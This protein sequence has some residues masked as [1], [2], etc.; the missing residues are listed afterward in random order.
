MDLY[1]DGPQMTHCPLTQR[2][3]FQA[4][5]VIFVLG[6]GNDPI[7]DAAGELEAEEARRVLDKG[8][9]A[10]GE[11]SPGTPGAVQPGEENMKPGVPEEPKPGIPDEPDPAP[12]GADGAPKPPPGQ[13]GVPN[14]PE[15]GVPEEPEAAP[16]GSPGGAAHAGKEAGQEVSGPQVIVRGEVKGEPGVGKIRIDLFDGDQRNVSGPRPKVV[17]V[18]ELE[19]LG[20]FAISIAESAGRIWLGAY[21]DVNGNKRPDKGEPFGWYSKNP[22]YTDDLPSKVVVTVEAEG[23]TTGLGLDFGE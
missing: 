6:C 23:K 20:A 14:E 11:D 5:S 16:P 3:M 19:G 9:G 18:H 12:P 2:A 7:L 21:R 17:G 1:Y 13:E 10:P 15:P 22:I 4:I 8:G